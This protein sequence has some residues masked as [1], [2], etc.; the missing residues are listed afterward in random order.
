MRV[1]VVD[2]DP[3]TQRLLRGQLE[4]A[5]YDVTVAGDGEDAL[6]AWL[7]EPFPLVLL[8]LMLPQLDGLGFARRVRAHPR[9]DECV[10]IVITSRD[11]TGDLHSVLDAGADDYI[12]KPVAPDVLQ[13]RMVIASRQ[14]R[15]IIARNR[16]ERAHRSSELQVASLVTNAPI[17]V[18]G[19]DRNDR[20]TTAR[21][22]EFEQIQFGNA[23]VIGRPFLDVLPR[24]G[25]LLRDMQ[26]AMRG[27]SFETTRP[28]LERTW[29][30][31][32]SPSV[33]ATGAIDG[34]TATATDIT[35][36]VQAEQ[37][38]ELSVLELSTERDE[39]RRLLHLLRQGV[40][41]V[42]L[43]EHISFVNSAAQQ[44]L[45]IT[46]H[47]VG[48]PWNEAIGIAALD[49]EVL[50]HVMTLPPIERVTQSIEIRR[51]SGVPRHLQIDIVDVPSV[52][53]RCA[54]LLC[55]VSDIIELRR[56]LSGSGS[57]QL[58]GRSNA[59]AILHQRLRECAQSD[60][61]VLLEGAS[62]VGRKSVARQLH[63]YSYRRAHPLTV[64]DCAYHSEPL[65][66]QW[67]LGTAE[68]PGYVDRACGGSVLID[69]IDHLSA[70]GQ[71]GLLRYLENREFNP[72]S[73]A[74]SDQ[75]RIIVGARRQ[76][77]E[78][79]EK[80]DFLSSLF[81]R[82]RM[83]RIR[84]PTLR[85]RREDIPLLVQYFIQQWSV[86]SG[87]PAPE[88]DRD[89]L[90]LLLQYRWPAN[91]RELRAAIEQMLINSGGASLTAGHLPPEIS[92]GA[93]SGESYASLDE[94]DQILRA[95][96]QAQGNRKKAAS[97]LN[98]S[99]AT[100]YRRLERLGIDLEG[101]S[102]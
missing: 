6:D 39:T 98:I 76:L 72:T 38:L 49:K 85:E 10:I 83:N 70:N 19:I 56:R 90:H 21:G 13:T 93:P 33:D 37:R 24:S 51:D 44:L 42:D 77:A 75:C 82:L 27:L 32:F 73:R 23:P 94:R 86:T 69:N 12:V 40:I 63:D 22:R 57:G 74:A 3:V 61:I 14:Y 60:W 96:D 20:I 88:I 87:R 26:K 28:L 78:A 84:I 65:L 102:I 101:S 71:S 81:T 2:D 64:V 41:L 8:D 91:V 5:G 89:S 36:R 52:I 31:W 30:I 59:M 66:M 54:I 95:L 62:G 9:G 45:A 34:A 1:L 99:R 50:R 55:D 97:L 35:E 25:D 68:E 46:P 43:N 53:G 58:I 48:L 18:L 79:V 7:A 92:E 80:G 47:A 15:S 29:S 17:L 11:G 4:K 67:W 16:A 100:L